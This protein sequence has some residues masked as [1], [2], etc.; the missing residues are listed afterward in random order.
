MHRPFFLLSAILGAT[1]LLGSFSANASTVAVGNC[2]RNLISYRTISEAI[3][4]V[5]AGSTVLVCPGTYP[6]EVTITISLTLRGVV[7]VNGRSAAVITVPSSGLSGP[8]V[9]VM[10]TDINNPPV[11]NISNLVVDGSGSTNATGIAFLASSGNLNGL[12]VRNQAFGID[13]GANPFLSSLTMSLQDSYIHDF[14][15]TGITFSSGGQVSSFL[16]ITRSIAKSSKTTVLSGILYDFVGGEISQSIILLQTGIGIQLKTVFNATTV[17]ENTITGADIGITM[18]PP[19]ATL[20]VKN[21]NLFGNATGISA[22]GPLTIN[23]NLI[24]QS[25]ATAIALNCFT[26]NTVSQNIIYGT[27]VGITNTQPGDT[28]TSNT[29]INVDTHTTECQ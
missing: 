8:Q 23:A 20:I 3:A 14:D 25:S 24:A 6:E 10:P 16:N 18:G 22:F 12:E 28:I 4:A 7:P 15:N 9:L 2:R 27:P 21:N 29:F 17:Q 19:L 26:D 1:T 13:F 5:S 11:V